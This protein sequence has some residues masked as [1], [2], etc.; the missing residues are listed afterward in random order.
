MTYI[1]VASDPAS[2]PDIPA[3][4]IHYDHVATFDPGDG[5]LEVFLVQGNCSWIYVVGDTPSVC[6]AAGYH[7][8]RTA[9]D[10]S[11]ALPRLQAKVSDA[12]SPGGE[13]WEVVKGS[14]VRIYR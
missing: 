12:S 14:S 7:V 3:S 6:L 11:G 9:V 4:H 13:L 10:S 2:R 1:N 5:T 8:L